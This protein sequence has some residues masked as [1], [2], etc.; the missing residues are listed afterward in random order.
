MDQNLRKNF[1]WNMVGSTV[2]SFTSL[3]FMII[4]TRINGVG[5]A[6]I[7]T[8]G[9]TLACL[10]Q[11]IGT[12]AG[13][14]YQVTERDSKLN[15]YDYIYQRIILCLLMFLVGLLFV[16]IKGYS[17]FKM[18]ILLLLVVYRIIDSASEVLYG[19]FQKND[20]LYKV[21]ISLFIK[22]VVSV[23][24]FFLIDYFT[25]NLILSTL[26]LVVVSLGVFLGYDYLQFRK[27]QI[28]RSRCD[29][30]KVKR[31]FIGGFFVFVFTF[32][33]QYVGSAPKYAI[34]DLLKGEYQTIFGIILMPATLMS[35][36]SQLII[37]PF[38]MSLNDKLAHKEYSRF[39]KMV[40]QICLAI[41]AIGLVGELLCYL[42]GIPFL[43]FVYGLE[44]N[45]YLVSLL[46]IIGG[47][48]LNGMT[49]VISVSLVAMREN[50]IQCIIYLVMAVLAFVTSYL[51][52]NRFGIVGAS[53]SYFLIMLFL[54]LIY[55]I[56]FMVIMR[57][58]FHEKEES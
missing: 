52:T 47:A 51:F 37:H 6:G 30:F 11:V 2:Y 42:V 26:V 20:E 48:I 57:R 53:W 24:L 21:G 39:K 16:L 45:K 34:D 19:I 4:V 31:I 27:Y 38:L 8:F 58:K 36:C 15:D 41:L 3:V 32:L 12:Y 17:N 28:K 5:E 18:I 7:F 10:L 55:L 29:F 23:L 49:A 50:F 35:L 46:V 1:I 43:E 40:F 22:S 44:L 13:R 25:V 54:F 56:I 9:Y 33:T 14:S